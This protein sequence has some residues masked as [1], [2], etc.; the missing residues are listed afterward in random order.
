[1]FAGMRRRQK[2]KISGQVPPLKPP[3]AH[4]YRQHQPVSQSTWRPTRRG[5]KGNEPQRQRCD[6]NNPSDEKPSRRSAHA[7]HADDDLCHFVEHVRAAVLIVHTEG[8]ER[9]CPKLTKLTP[10]YGRC[11]LCRL[12]LLQARLSCCVVRAWERELKGPLIQVAGST[13]RQPRPG[14]DGVRWRAVARQTIFSGGHGE[15][16]PRRAGSS[17]AAWSFRMASSVAA[18]WYKAMD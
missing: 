7:V 15:V 3:P 4:H 17:W 2:D 5:V 16:G 8:L 14:G 13:V 12:H 6:F 1:M 11:C 10:S 18:L 9:R